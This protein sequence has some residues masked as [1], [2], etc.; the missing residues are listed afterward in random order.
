MRKLKLFAVL[1]LVLLRASALGQSDYLAEEIALGLDYRKALLTHF[2]EVT[3]TKEAFL[4]QSVFEKLRATPVFQYAPPLPYRLT[5]I[6]SEAVNAYAFAGGQV[7]VPVGMAGMLGSNAGEWAA[8]LGHELG[9]TAGR[10]HFRQAWRQ[11]QLQAQIEYYKRRAELGDTNAQWALL[12]ARIGGAI[13]QTKLSRD[14]EHEADRM[15]VFMMVQAGY[16]PAFA[17]TFYRRIRARLGD[18][19]KFQAFFSSHPRWETREERAMKVYDEAEA[20]FNARWPDPALSP[21]GAPPVIATLGKIAAAQDKQM[22]SAVLTVPCT[23]HNAKDQD[24][25]VAAVFFSKNGQA[26]SA[27]PEY[28][29]NKGGLIAVMKYQPSSN[30]ES[31]SVG[32]SIPTAAV[33][34]G[35]RKLKARIIIFQGDEVLDASSEINIS[36]PKP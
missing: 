20:Y 13:G 2:G 33:A 21:G 26:L 22:K 35:E 16:H 7:Y 18:E 3:G 11:L 5:L 25:G 8:V 1:L 36:F 23:F 34:G 6:N 24:I 15:G 31:S 19:S 10:H 27:L 14:D 12:G 32:L 4:A 17:I 29:N 30:K 28:S 9:H